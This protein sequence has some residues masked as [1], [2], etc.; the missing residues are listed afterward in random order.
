MQQIKFVVL[1]A[2]HGDASDKI[3]NLMRLQTVRLFLGRIF[4]YVGYQR[5]IR[6]TYKR[7]S[8]F[9]SQHKATASVRLLG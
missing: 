8:Q 2:E 6:S 7:Q 1:E 5:K 3:Q 9:L 4:G